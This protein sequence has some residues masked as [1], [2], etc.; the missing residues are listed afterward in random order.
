MFKN[1]QILNFV[2]NIFQILGECIYENFH[3][4]ILKSIL[5][6]SHFSYNSNWE[7]NVLLK[8]YFQRNLFPSNYQ[9]FFWL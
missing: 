4:Q 6:N 2:E 9:I 5:I 1:F 7:I 8:K 3:T